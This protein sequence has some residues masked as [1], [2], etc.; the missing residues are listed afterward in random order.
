MRY[1]RLRCTHKS[2]YTY[3]SIMGTSNDVRFIKIIPDNAVL[4]IPA[5]EHVHEWR[6]LA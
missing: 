6:D 1:H 2:Y 3:H 4:L 5:G